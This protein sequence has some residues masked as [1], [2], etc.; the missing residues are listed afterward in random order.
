MRFGFQK[1]RAD[2]S[3]F[4]YSS[5]EVLVYFLVYGDDIILTGS[6]NAILEHFVTILAQRFSL[7]DLGPLHHFL[8]VEVIPTS[9]GMFLSQAR[10]ITDILV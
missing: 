10:Y 2:A 6:D 3:L 8:G 4:I 1:S 9:S 5:D 7:K